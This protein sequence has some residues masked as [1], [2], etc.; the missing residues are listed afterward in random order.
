M[1]LN[2]CTSKKKSSNMTSVVPPVPFVHSM[3]KSLCK[4]EVIVLK[5]QTAPNQTR[6]VLTRK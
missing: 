4:D 6:N 2:I 5:L 1:L 3:T